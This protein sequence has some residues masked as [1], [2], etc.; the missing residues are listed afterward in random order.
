MFF[1]KSWILYIYV[2]WDVTMKAIGKNCQSKS[3]IPKTSNGKKY[4]TILYVQSRW[5]WPTFSNLFNNLTEV[6]HALKCDS[7]EPLPT[8]ALPHK[9]C[10]RIKN[11]SA[12]SMSSQWM[13]FVI[14]SV[15]LFLSTVFICKLH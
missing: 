3:V 7:S 15:I 4:F 12:A 8:I 1:S 13:C 9:V 10:K 6:K 14:R 11:K 2:S 5:N